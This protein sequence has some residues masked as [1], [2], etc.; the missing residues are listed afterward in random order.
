MEFREL[1]KVRRSCRSFQA[2]PVTEGELNAIIDAG[3]WAPNPL[4]LQ[5]W[6]FIII[7]DQ[8]VK[9]Q[10]REIAEE[11]K[12]EAHKKSGANWVAEYGLDFLIEA[13][14]LIVVLFNP[15]KGGLGEHFGQKYGA[16]S[17]ASACIQNM[18]LAAA[19]IGLATLWFTFF[20]PEKLRAVL[21]FPENLEVAGVIPLG[22]PKETIKPPP[23]KDPKLHSQRYSP[24]S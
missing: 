7:T 21:G 2:A 18:M 22:R 17:G 12:Q 10:I 11:A 15:K 20:R 13:P 24:G 23:R 9:S 4:N 5:P 1:V 3:R 8:K 19:D 16:L 6:E 14:M